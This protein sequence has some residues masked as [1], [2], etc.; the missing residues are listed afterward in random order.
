MGKYGKTWASDRYEEG[1]C[2]RMVEWSYV[3]K[4]YYYYVLGLVVFGDMMFAKTG[5]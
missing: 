2:C 4:R 3:L 5:E 1:L